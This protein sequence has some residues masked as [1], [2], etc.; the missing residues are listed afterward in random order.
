MPLLISS[1]ILEVDKPTV[2]GRIYPRAVVAKMVKQLEGVLDTRPVFGHYAQ[3]KDDFGMLSEEAMKSS[4]IDWVFTIN[5][6]I[7]SHAI[8]EVKLINDKL[9][10]TVQ[11]L[12]TIPGTM[13]EHA[14]KNGKIAFRPIG[15]GEVNK[16]GVVTEY[17]MISV[18]AYDSSLV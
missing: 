18:G 13:L 9:Q 1:V 6:T 16:K 10:V 8:K 2:N 3:S 17:T 4:K 11:T 15:V 5:P 14:I 7:V 12:K